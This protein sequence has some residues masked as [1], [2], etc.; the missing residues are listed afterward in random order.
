MTK[1]LGLILVVAITA[2]FCGTAAGEQGMW[3]LDQLELL[4][5]KSKGLEIDTEDIYRPDGDCLAA[6]T[7]LLGGGTSAFV[8]PNGLMLTNHHVAYGGVQRASTQGT[9]YLTNG[10][11]A[12]SYEEEIQAP[13]VEAL[14]IQEIR[15]VT[16][17][18][19]AAGEGIEDLVK[20]QRAI[21]AKI[22]EMTDAI[23]EE[24]DDMDARIASMYNGKEYQLYVYKR[25]EDIRVVYMPPLA[26]GNYGGDIDNWMWPRH[27]GDFA[28]ARAYVSP[29]GVGRKYDPENVPY[30]PE[31]WLQVSTRD[32]DPGDLAFSLGF[33]GTTT[34]YRTYN[35]AKYWYELELPR[36]IE[37]YEDGIAMLDEVGQDSPMAEMKVAGFKKGLANAHK[38]Y[39]GMLAA[40]TGYDFVNSKLRES[41][42][43]G[44][45]INSKKEYRE[46]YGGVT[47]EIAELYEPVIANKDYN[48][49]LD[50]F[51]YMA[52]TLAGVANGI[53]YTVMEREKPDEDRDPNFS[54][55]DV[56]R[57]ISRLDSRYMAYYEPA[58][59]MG[60]EYMLNKA[61][62]LPDEKRVK[63]LDYILKDSE[64]SIGEWAEFIIG[65]TQL[66]DLSFVKPLY[67]KTSEELEALGDPMIDLA[68]AVYPERDK[69]SDEREEFSAKIRDLRKKYNEA[70]LL[71]KG[72]AVYPD[73]NR[74]M[75]FSYGT[76][77]GYEPR[78]AISYLPFTKLGGV[79]AKDTGEEPFNV[80]E[81]LKEL[82]AA[83]DFGRWIDP[84]LD[85]VP[86]AF[87][88]DCDGTGGSSGSPVLNSK[89]EMIGIAFDG[90]MEARLGDWKYD[91]A[92]AREICVD[93]RYVLFVTEKYAGADFLLKELGVM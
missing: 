59:R 32:L 62:A 11:L 77:K 64:R 78:D 91:P 84:E 85:D 33:P 45:F 67:H 40:M 34:R 30:R 44:E 54:E 68:I 18:V 46:E 17:E 89:G 55:D 31:N 80:P 19:L 66:D 29:D 37:L 6:A 74:T 43:L 8:S 42:E 20:R 14:L 76:V 86:V 93:M 27:T 87:I 22:Q 90:V 7:V 51:G 60:L 35:S 81:K 1:L 5:L 50:L 52:G 48:D 4:E 56:E 39:E 36:S 12:E 82:Y 15:D 28:F 58:D 53:V 21:D 73:A 16:D 61:A 83:R 9:D 57:G 3:K 41:R 88:V 69:Q 13:G 63:G 23:E 65:N 10:F 47:D 71:W 79:I 24:A 26:I 38:N 75:R 92:V 49:V 2:G 70:L 25:F 72:G